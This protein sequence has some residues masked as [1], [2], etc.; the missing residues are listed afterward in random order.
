MMVVMLLVVVHLVMAAY[1]H[2]ADGR[3]AT[4]RGAFGH[5]SNG[6]CAFGRGAIGHGAFWSWN[7]WPL[8][9]LISCYL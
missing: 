9:L 1:S 4:G 2:G 3:Y 8:V 6:P 7:Y 5:G